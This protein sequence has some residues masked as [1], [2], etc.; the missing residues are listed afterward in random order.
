MN[1]HC[2]CYCYE[3]EHKKNSGL[4]RMSTA[5]CRIRN[6]RVMALWLWLTLVYLLSIYTVW[7][8]DGWLNEYPQIFCSMDVWTFVY[9]M[10]YNALSVYNLYLCS[11]IKC[12]ESELGKNGDWNGNRKLFRRRRCAPVHLYNFDE[13]GRRLA[14]SHTTT[15]TSKMFQRDSLSRNRNRIYSYSHQIEPNYLCVHINDISSIE[16]LDSR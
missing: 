15:C 13:D 9:N 7:V 11:D 6:Q 10:V 4:S 8:V 14:T 5:E 3:K 12:R 2:Y 1:M 16:I